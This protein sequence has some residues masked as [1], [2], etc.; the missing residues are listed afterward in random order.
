MAK[1]DTNITA[2]R[3]D[4]I[5]FIAELYD[6]EGAA[7]TDDLDD[8]YFSCKENPSD[9]DYV[10]Q[11]SLSAGITKSTTGVY[12]VR[13]APADTADL[14]AGTYYYDF[15]ITIGDDVYTPLKGKLILEEDI[16][17]GA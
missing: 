11:K 8:A 1:T 16:T 12:L 9:S 14:E 4:T 5:E 7:L 17:R 6:D 10:F 13:V 15:E 3:G 2:I